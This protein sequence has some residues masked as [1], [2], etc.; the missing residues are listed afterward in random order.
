M[1]LL[2]S[3]RRVERLLEHVKDTGR[4]AYDS[5]QTIIGCC[6]TAGNDGL[7]RGAKR[8]YL[9]SGA[10]AAYG[11]LQSLLGC[12]KMLMAGEQC[13]TREFRT[14]RHTKFVKPLR[15]F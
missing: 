5:P 13:D 4:R 10:C 6:C 14:V 12:G 9:L 11:D 2:F 15:G 1:P 8:T 7:T 3:S